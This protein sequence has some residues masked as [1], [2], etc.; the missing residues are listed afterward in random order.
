MDLYNDDQRFISIFSEYGRFV[1]AMQGNIS[2]FKSV[3]SK[4]GQQARIFPR[5]VERFSAVQ[6]SYLVGIEVIP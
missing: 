1:V 2:H 6:S 3:G 5:P 4:P